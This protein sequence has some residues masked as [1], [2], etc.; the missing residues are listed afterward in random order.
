MSI[1]ARI[2]P[3]ADFFVTRSVRKPLTSISVIAASDKQ[4]EHQQIWAKSPL[5]RKEE[6]PIPTR[7]RKK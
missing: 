6:Q 1:R 5:R 7:R 2:C 3:A 4:R